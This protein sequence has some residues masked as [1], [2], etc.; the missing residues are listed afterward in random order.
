MFVSRGRTH[1]RGGA[2][3]K[4][5]VRMRGKHELHLD[6]IEGDLPRHR[7]GA[8]W[9]VMV[10]SRGVCSTPKRVTCHVIRVGPRGV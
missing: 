5:D 7:G 1:A 3:R 4:A 2:L 9:G 10:G 6:S 8:P